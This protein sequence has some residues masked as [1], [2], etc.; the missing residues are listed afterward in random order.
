MF[1]GDSSSG[2]G[3]VEESYKAYMFMRRGG[4]KRIGKNL[5]HVYL[6]FLLSRKIIK[7]LICQNLCCLTF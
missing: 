5:E 1:M 3:K 7:S 4:T 6:T 2:H